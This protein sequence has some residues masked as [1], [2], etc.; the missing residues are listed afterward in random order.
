MVS[1]RRLPTSLRSSAPAEVTLGAC[2]TSLEKLGHYS[3][4][5]QPRFPVKHDGSFMVQLSS[6]PCQDR[7]LMIHHMAA[8]EGADP[9]PL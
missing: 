2:Q 4:S 6:D 8:C 3:V 5:Q 9:P 7:G 1:D